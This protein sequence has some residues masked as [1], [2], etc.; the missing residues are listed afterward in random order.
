MISAESPLWD[1]FLQQIVV[2]DMTAP[3]VYVGRFVGVRSGY[4]LLEQADAHDLR[5][6]STSREVYVLE[7]RRHGVRP[8][9]ERV[10]VDLRQ[11]VGISALD[12]VVAF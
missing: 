7:C 6:S 11:V 4:L 10:F 3:Y 5:D 1:E 9:R 8:N 12:D 2:L